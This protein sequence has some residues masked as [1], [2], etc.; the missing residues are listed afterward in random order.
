MT[1]ITVW[2]RT[3]SVLLGVITNLSANAA[4]EVL[5][6]QRCFD[7]HVAICK[8]LTR[9]EVML[10]SK[11]NTVTQFNAYKT[12]KTLTDVIYADFESTLVPGKFMQK[13]DAQ[14][15]IVRLKKTTSLRNTRP[16]HSRIRVESSVYRSWGWDR[17]CLSWG[18]FCSQI[19]PNDRRSGQKI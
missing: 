16:T 17:Y 7:N 5:P 4:C 19:Y 12:N 2:S 1:T 3:S 14:G 9:K 15:N 6:V 10:R 11:E 8:G 13:K 18:R